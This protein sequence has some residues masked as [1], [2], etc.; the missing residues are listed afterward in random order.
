MLLDQTVIRIAMAPSAVRKLLQ[1]PV[2][3]K[4]AVLNRRIAFANRRY[5][6]NALSSDRALVIDYRVG[7]SRV[8]ESHSRGLFSFLLEPASRVSFILQPYCDSAFALPPRSISV[9]SCVPIG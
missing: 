2:Q 1:P 9:T 4:G 6:C 5:T 3:H 8:S 7:P